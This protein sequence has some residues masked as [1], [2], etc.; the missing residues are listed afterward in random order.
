MRR[1]VIAG[2]WKMNMLP[3][4]TIKFID[5]IAPL[6]KDT[7][8]E[9]ILCVPYTDLFY[10]LLT[11]QNT[12]IKIGAQNMHWEEKGAFTGEVSGKMLKAIGVKY[13]IIGHSERK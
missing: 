9:V 11:A 12:N 3:D 13:V 6:V 10:A 2:N 7:E 1:K 4:E 8:N 5:E